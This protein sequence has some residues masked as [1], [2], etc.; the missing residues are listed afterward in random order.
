MPLNTA[1]AYSIL[2]TYLGIFYS[3]ATIRSLLEEGKFIL[4]SSQ[5]FL[6]PS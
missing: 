5:V 1:L 4:G 2:Y 6:M 3:S